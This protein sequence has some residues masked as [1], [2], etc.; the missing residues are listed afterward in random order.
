M[1]KYRVK[2]FNDFTEPYWTS[3]DPENGP[4]VTHKCIDE[5]E[6]DNEKAFRD[7][8]DGFLDA[9]NKPLTEKDIRKDFDE[10]REPRL[11]SSRV[12]VIKRYYNGRLALKK[13]VY[14]DLA[15][16][17]MKKMKIG[18][19]KMLKYN[20]SFEMNYFSCEDND[21]C[22]TLTKMN[23]SYIEIEISKEE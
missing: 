15:K 17:D 1:T 10:N 5:Y 2:L 6:M 19:P 11:S 12:E 23:E 7:V 21:P 22:D 4:I 16:I 14:A 8:L 9:P 13:Q 3:D 20:I 18:F